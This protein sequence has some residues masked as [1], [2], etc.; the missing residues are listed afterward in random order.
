MKIFFAGNIEYGS[1]SLGRM[2]AFQN[3]G[4]SV[5]KFDFRMYLPKNRIL[6]AFL[7]R[8][9]LK[10]LAKKL[11]KSFVEEINK[12]DPDLI[13]VDKGL[14]LFPETLQSIS[15]KKVH[16]NPDDPFGHYKYGW[17]IFKKSIPF[18][19]IHFVPRPQ[20]IK[21]YLGYGAKK[22]IEYDRS[23]NRK[24]HYPVKLNPEE[25]KKYSVEVGFIGSYAE[26]RSNSIKYLIK[27]GIDV[28]V[29]GPGW[30]KEFQKSGLLR[31]VKSD[32]IY[33]DEYRKVICGMR[34]ALHFLRKE[35]RDFQDSRSFEIPACGTFMLAERSYKHEEFFEDGKEAVYFNTDK[36]L[37]DKVKFY[38]A[39]PNLI[40]D[41]AKAGY[42]RSINS[43]YDHESRLCSLLKNIDESVIESNFQ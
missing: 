5:L 41:I 12:F 10:F 1:H 31:Y 27:N 37:L 25:K 21:E 18:Y 35:N 8:Y 42:V 29:Y 22:V 40:G 4:H 13:W 20:N 3:I 2:Q 23:Y 39:N 16:F 14:Y 36:E 43:G 9:G 15:Q 11:N 34:I 38:L 17:H 24:L 7:Y 28:Y 6:N 33:G 30:K 19:D 32:A 26:A